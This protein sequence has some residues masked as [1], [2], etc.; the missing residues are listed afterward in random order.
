[1]G[2][3]VRQTCLASKEKRA[4]ES[5]Y[6]NREAGWLYCILESLG[7]KRKTTEFGS[8]KSDFQF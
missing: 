4:C 2:F 1:M 5:S 7:Y 8:R 3:G 6:L